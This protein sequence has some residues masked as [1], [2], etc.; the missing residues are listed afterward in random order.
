MKSKRLLLT[1]LMALLVPWAANAQQALPYS[2]GFED[3]DLSTDGWTTQNPSGYDAS[4]FGI[5]S[6]AAR[7]GDY[8]FRFSSYNDNYD[9]T[10]YLISPELSATTGVVVQFYYKASST[11]GTEIFKV[12]YSTTDAE[13]SSFTFGSEISTS[14]T[15]W[16]LSDEFTFPANTKYVAVYYY[17]K[18]QYRLYVDDFSF[19]VPSSCPKPTLSQEVATTATTATVSWTPSNDG[20]Q[21][22]DLYWAT[23]N[24]A[25]TEATTPSAANQSGT[26]YE[27]A[28]A[29]LNA[30]STYYVWV[31]GNCGTATDP[32]ISGGWAGPVSF[33]TPCD[34]VT[35]FPWSVDFED[36]TANTVPQCW[37]N[38]MSGSSTLNS[39]PHYIW[40][41]YS[42]NNNQMLRMYNYYVYSGTTIINSPTIT[43]PAEGDYELSFKYSHNAS[44]GAFSV[45]ISEDGGTTFVEKGSYTKGSGSSQT[46]PGTFTEVAPISLA[47][48]A[49]KSIIVQFYATANYDSGAI[50]VDDVKIDL[51][52]PTIASVVGN[53]PLSTTITWTG[54]TT[55]TGYAY[56]YKLATAT[57]WGTETTV[58][59]TVLSA[60]LTTEAEEDYDF[61]VRAVYGA[62]YSGYAT[63]SF[64]APGYCMVPSNLTITNVTDSEATFSWTEEFGDGKWKFG[65]KKNSETEYT[66]VDVV[67]ADLPITLDVF[68]EQ[69]E[70]DVVVYP[71]CD[72]TKTLED[73]FTTKCAPNTSFPW[74]EDF[75]DFSATSSYSGNNTYA[76]SDPCWVNEHLEGNGTYLFQVTSY[77]QGGNSS[78]KLELPDMSNGTMTKL[79]LPGM[80]LPN[81]N[82][83]F[84]I[85]VYRN[86]STANYGEGIRV[87]AST[88]GEIEGATELAFIS[89]SYATSDNN[90]IP[91]ESTSGWYT[92]ELPIGMS[93]ICYII[94][95]GE[96][97]Y[98]SATYMDNFVIEQIPT[99]RKPT[100]VTKSNVT[101][102]SA[103]LSWTNGEEG[104][105]AWQ[106]AY[107]AGATFDPTDA[108]ALAT[109][110]VID[111]TTNPYTFNQTLAAATTY[112]MY[113]R[114]NCGDG[115]YSKWSKTV[116]SFT[117]AVAAPAPTSFTASNFSS[118]TA[119]LT[120]T[121]PAGD[122][123]SGYELYYV[124][125]TEAPEAPTAETEATVTVTLEE[126]PTTEAP[127][128]LTGLTAETQ[129]Y[130]WVRANHGADG[131]SAWTALTGSSFT[132][133]AAC[134]AM[135]PVVSNIGHYTATVSWN[136]ESNDG[137]TVNYRTAAGTDA[138]F[139]EDFENGIGSWTMVSCASS[140]G[141]S[142]S[143]NHTEG[144]SQGFMFCYNSNPPQYLISPLLTGDI[145]GKDL[146]FYYK[147]YSSSWPETFKVGYSS[148]TSSTD[149]FTFGDEITMSDTDWH[150]F[151]EAV[152]SGTKYI[153]IQY[154]SNNQ[155]YLYIDDITIGAY[156]V[157]AGEPQ[158]VAATAT[159]ASLEDLTAG[160]KYDLWVV[161]NCDETLASDIIQFTTVSE[162][163]KYFLGTESSEW[164]EAGNW[165]PAGAPSIDQNVE[166]RANATITGDAEAKKITTGNFTLTIEDGGKLMTDNSVTATVKKHITSYEN[167]TGD[168]IGGYYL[169]AN[170][171]YT[172]LTTTS[173]PTIGST[174]LL[175][176]NYD[177]YD[178]SYSASD[179]LEW[180]N[181]K[182][183]AFTFNTGL[184][185]YLY[186]NE[187]DVDLT[188]T[189]TV[190]A[191]NS[192]VSRYLS[193]TTS[194][195]YD[196]PAWY[197]IGNPFVCDA[198]LV[199]ASTGGTA[200]AYYK[201]KA[202]G[203]EFEAVATAEA[204]A[205]MEGIF[206]QYQA[207]TSGYVYFV[208]E[209]PVASVNPGT[210]NINLAQAVTNRGE[211]GATDNAIIRFGEGN[212]LEK[213]SFRE[214]S[215]KVYIPM[216]NKDYAVVNAGNVGEMPVS[217]KAEHNGSYTLSFN[218]QEVSFSYLHLIDNMT[219]NDVDLLANPS[220]SFN[221]Q[222][223]DYASRFRLVFATGSSADGDSFGFINGMGNLCIFG[224]EGTAT[225]QV[226][227][228]LGHVISSDTFSGSYERKLNAAPGV[229][230][231]RLIQGNDVKVQKMIVR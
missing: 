177:L 69:T 176:D 33:E 4:E 44:C 114:A 38:S 85:D 31:R 135:D 2:Y 178:W 95:R 115:D 187:N 28:F 70:Y 198:Y 80:N 182:T 76:L 17:A 53:T 81:A 219:G 13:I 101:N 36:M 171:I 105:T 46:D 197:L 223:T 75:K 146:E 107:K 11:Y 77:T 7:T 199:N 90:L 57:D 157:P 117:T 68:E 130:I 63:T 9:H 144:G 51:P 230:M 116:C 142:S 74:S 155:Y 61:R 125:A 216:D 134:A 141:L 228:V 231:V 89:R 143:A 121:A 126:A 98:G 55:A 26:S 83:Q 203:D 91:A 113:V 24:T 165:E 56:Q 158:T 148:S 71:L 62:N 3:N 22:F 100:D 99:C 213:F 19:T 39:S 72:E 103:T 59:A 32:D 29:D 186:A 139:G 154:T 180:R 159:T 210:L 170:P 222:T 208:R 188:F 200:L 123:L 110:T 43:L 52:A 106:I 190:R 6:A 118:T 120:W 218:A 128:P 152:P 193:A 138:E 149:A 40:G 64:T 127:Y 131:Y 183:S 35:T 67:A 78:N 84:A 112:Y 73:S 16:T 160:Q 30:S 226:V 161:P 34:A 96:S 45:K 12:G 169:I 217:F 150:L 66:Y 27:F 20:Q 195:T 174:G 205:P 50:F 111:V 18:Y 14:S 65:Y 54:S 124:A 229:Y 42:Y 173:T 162:N 191:N 108:E 23:S 189:G 184:Y 122:F 168:K 156:E 1:L 194:T 166:L 41:V 102:H 212:T 8:G 109:A 163:E 201:M 227:D 60:N 82:Y 86:T 79:V 15:S 5:Y 179:G 104:Q 10:Q 145:D 202:A 225:V 47:T 136:G 221:A 48:Y 181:Y 132:T 192:S 214:N 92:Y 25:P 133:T 129:Y 204:I 196:W 175:S 206:Y 58:G 215:T 21:L 207:E 94:L 137:F 49:G 93:G 164:L 147:Q 140:T 167:Y 211:K 151:S 153:C 172:S 220:Y 224:I 119:D 209:L 37:D 88:D 97:K 87:F 185:G